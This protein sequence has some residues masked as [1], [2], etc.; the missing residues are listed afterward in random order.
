M[1]HVKHL[2]LFDLLFALWYNDSKQREKLFAV[3]FEKIGGVYVDNVM[4]DTKA[5]L[6][7][8]LKSRLSWFVDCEKNPFT[9][10]RMFFY[11]NNG[12]KAL[13]A[14]DA[15]ENALVK[16]YDKDDVLMFELEG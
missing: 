5:N 4:I 16:M 1:F 3:F 13:S 6:M 11:I 10:M 2:I 12:I 15:D 7:K 8:F 9:E 14:L